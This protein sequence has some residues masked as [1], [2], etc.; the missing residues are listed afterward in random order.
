MSPKIRTWQ[1]NFRRP[2]LKRW[3]PPLQAT[4]FCVAGLQMGFA[5]QWAQQSS[6]LDLHL[7]ASGRPPRFQT[8]ARLRKESSESCASTAAAREAS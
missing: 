7:T 2:S 6:E 5:A 4:G 3:G 1:S 8:S